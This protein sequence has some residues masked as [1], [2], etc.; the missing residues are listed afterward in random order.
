MENV[1][2]KKSSYIGYAYACVV[3]DSFGKT[4]LVRTNTLDN[5]ILFN[6]IHQL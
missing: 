1:V 2:E 3:I 6:F 5:A 4:I